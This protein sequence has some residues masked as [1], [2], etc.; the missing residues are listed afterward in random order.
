M[1]RD[2][3]RRSDPLPAVHQAF[4]PTTQGCAEGAI[5]G[6]RGPMTDPKGVAARRIPV[7]I[8]L[9]SAQKKATTPMGLLYFAFHADPG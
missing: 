3:A 1:C 8:S 4:R 7:L 9:R 6:A 5:L 2:P